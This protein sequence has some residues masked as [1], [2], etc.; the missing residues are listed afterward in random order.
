MMRIT[1]QTNEF[2]APR[3]VEKMKTLPSAAVLMFA[4]PR[5]VEKRI[6]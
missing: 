5:A 1:C 3:A 2:A 6:P 4:A